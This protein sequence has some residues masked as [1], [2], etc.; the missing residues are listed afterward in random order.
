[1]DCFSEGPACRAGVLSR[2]TANQHEELEEKLAIK[3]NGYIETFVVNETSQDVWFDNHLL[4]S[5]VKASS[6]PVFH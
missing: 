3:K 6:C 1:M 5:L 2:N 4:K